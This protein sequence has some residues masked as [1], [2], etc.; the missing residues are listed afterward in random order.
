MSL[1]ITIL[2]ENTTQVPFG[3]TAEHG[4]SAFVE[5]ERGNFLFDTGQGRVL[6]SNSLFLGKDLRSIKFLALSHGHFDHVLGIPQVLELTGELDVYGHPDIFLERY[7]D[8]KDG[9]L[10]SIGMPYCRS[11]LESLGARFQL[12][13]EFTEVLDNVYL[14]GEIPRMTDFEKTDRN[15]VIRGEKGDWV[16][17]PIR[18]DLSMFMDTPK[19]LVVLL[20]CG[21]AGIINIIEHAKR[22]TGKEKVHAV[23]GGTHLMFSDPEQLE[24]SIEAL[25]TLNIDLVGGSHCTGLKA[26]AILFNTLKDKFFFATAGSV[27][28]V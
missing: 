19:G 20:G 13:K 22:K 25:E 21:H 15:M 3:V 16:Q 11:Y 23:L 28:E 12:K 14:S 4:F 24:R 9:R 1:R 6:M 26:G 27:L 10:Q 18:D 5:T 7:W 2:A 8:H 17:D